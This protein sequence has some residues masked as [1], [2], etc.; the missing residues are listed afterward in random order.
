MR[1]AKEGSSIV[2]GAFLVFVVASTLSIVH[3]TLW[4]YLA[5]TCF[6][7]L[8]FSLYF[9]R[10]PQRNLPAGDQIIIAPADGKIVRIMKI[11]DSEIGKGSTLVS[12]FL[13]VFNVHVNRMPISGKFESVAYHNGKFL[14]AFDHKASDENERTDIIIK[15][16]KITLRI[17][18]IAG[19][20][21]RRILCY[22]EADGEMKIGDR[23]GFI[24]FGSRTDLVLPPSVKINVKLN[25]KVTGNV[26]IIGEIE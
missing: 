17:K 18:Q 21:A 7:F 10:D 4:G 20:I 3:S 25:Q 1:L 8:I 12:I 19:I 24:R 5:G 23:L 14:V 13:N 15:S 26:T 16:K 9:F 2:I 6:L 22:A 11:D